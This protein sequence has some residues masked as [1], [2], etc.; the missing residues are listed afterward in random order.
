MFLNLKD[1]NINDFLD[2][3]EM[4]YKKYESFFTFKILI[5]FISLFFRDLFISF[6]NDYF[7]QKIFFKM[8]FKEWEDYIINFKIDNNSFLLKIS[9]F[10]NKLVMFNNKQ[11]YMKFN[12]K[13]L[14][15]F[16]ILN[17]YEILRDFYYGNYNLNY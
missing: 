2:I 11:I 16:L 3:S 6:Y 10:L 12:K 9:E 17:V 15:T 7:K 8:I 4:L 14:Y 1:Y 13:I 5:K